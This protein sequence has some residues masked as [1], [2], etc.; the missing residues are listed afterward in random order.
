[1]FLNDIKWDIT[2]KCF[3]KCSFC[4]N[5]AERCKTH[6]TDTSYDEKC[7]I[8]DQCAINRIS[9][10]QLLGGEP[11]YTPRFFDLL[12]Y[13]ASKNIAVGINTNGVMLSN[14]NIN[15]IISTNCVNDIV[16]S[17]DGL[18]DTHN[19]IRGANIYDKVLK[20]VSLL[21]TKRNQTHSNIS[22]GINTVLKKENINEIFTLI[23][24]LNTIG[25]DY[26]NGLELIDFDEKTRKYNIVFT[27]DEILD[28]LKELGELQRHIK[29][30]IIPLFTF[31][32]IVSY[33]N[34]IN[35]SNL[36]IPEH[37]CNAGLS[38][39]YLDWKGRI[40]PCD[41]VTPKNSDTSIIYKKLKQKE[42]LL[43][44]TPLEDCISSD[45]FKSFS[46]LYADE[47]II[48]PACYGCPFYRH[49]CYPCM[50]NLKYNTLDNCCMHCLE[51]KKRIISDFIS[52]NSSH[53]SCELYFIPRH[54]T[55]YENKTTKYV[56]DLKKGEAYEID[57]PMIQ[58]IICA[59]YN[60]VH[61]TQS[62]LLCTVLL[63]KI[64]NVNVLQNDVL[65]DTF[66]FFMQDLHE[67]VENN[68]VHTEQ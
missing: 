1:M 27:L 8:I 62:E 52:S 26:W 33:A 5:A 12:E 13:I 2:S 11:L 65:N 34:K 48:A 35:Q 9:H 4:I 41:R 39:V 54:I 63:S 3:L 24:V 23:G 43:Q 7:A 6:G 21:I 46:F 28:I 60:Q 14:G 59:L 30:K 38:F 68:I 10:I 29:T 25:V 64:L 36:T 19:T 37:L 31:P 17:L 20:N 45:L 44:N 42:L 67:L 66:N 32:F 50:A 55:Y 49:E 56:F 16:V 58:S 47:D 18:K 57:S 15:R 22:I 53:I 40:Y 51:L 61:K